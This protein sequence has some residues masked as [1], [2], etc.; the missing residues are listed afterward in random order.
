[1]NAVI[2][3]LLYDTVREIATDYATATTT[4]IKDTTESVQEHGAV[5]TRLI[6]AGKL[7]DD[8]Q[9]SQDSRNFQ[10]RL[11]RYTHDEYSTTDRRQLLLLLQADAEAATIPGEF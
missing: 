7:T 8:S 1:M 10:D 11:W 4:I 2:D 3:N 9:A 6:N 5:V